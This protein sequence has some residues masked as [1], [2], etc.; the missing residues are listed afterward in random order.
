MPVKIN[1][2]ELKEGS[3]QFEIVTNAREIGLDENLVKDGI[4]VEID[5]FKAP[6]QIDFDVQVEGTFILCCDRCLEDYSM[7]FKTNFELVYIQKQSGEERIQ[8]DYVKLYDSFTKSLDITED[9]REYVLV[10]VPMRKV[11][12]ETDG[13]CSWC[14][15]SNEMW[16]ADIIDVHKQ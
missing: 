15:K 16:K 7:Q 3:Q 2:A 6:T 4:N 8:D 9:L 12:E 14:G 13:K 5:V 11:P 10:A 1:I